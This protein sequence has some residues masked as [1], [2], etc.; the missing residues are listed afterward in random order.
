MKNN[1]IVCRIQS[2]IWCS[3]QKIRF[4]RGSKYHESVNIELFK[5]EI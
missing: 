2:S 1:I 3:W 5:E 4:N